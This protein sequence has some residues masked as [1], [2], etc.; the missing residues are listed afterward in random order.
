LI[1]QYPHLWTR[2]ETEGVIARHELA[3]DPASAL[4]LALAA[5]TL[6]QRHKSAVIGAYIE[7]AI[8]AARDLLGHEAEAQ[9]LWLAVWER[10]LQLRDEFALY[11]LFVIPA[12]PQHDIGPLRLD[13]RFLGVLQRHIER[14]VPAFVFT[15]QNGLDGASTAL[16]QAAVLNAIGKPAQRAKLA[17]QAQK[18]GRSLT[19]LHIPADQ[20]KRVAALAA[21]AATHA[22]TRL[23]PPERR[24]HFQERFFAAWIA[25]IDQVQSAMFADVTR[26]RA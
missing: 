22:L 23:L 26:L 21:R 2:A 12:A 19:R 25:A 6:A 14:V 10:A 18:L 7:G 16:L 15:Q 17:V 11:D 13:E 8:A 9:T 3:H 24:Q 5:L 20:T 4:S 1:A